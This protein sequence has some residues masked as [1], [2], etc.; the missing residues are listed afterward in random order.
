ME[1]N[2]YDC[3]EENLCEGCG[4]CEGFAQWEL[5]PDDGSLLCCDCV[6]DL[7]DG[8]VPQEWHHD[9]E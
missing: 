7:F 2:Y 4:E 1:D 6:S 9:D 5:G 8:P 3:S